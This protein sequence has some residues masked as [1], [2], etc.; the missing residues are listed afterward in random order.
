MTATTRL[1]CRH[2]SADSW[3]YWQSILVVVVTYHHCANGLLHDMNLTP[4]EF[5][6]LPEKEVKNSNFP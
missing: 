4:N 1:L 2:P 5:E 6:E 3:R